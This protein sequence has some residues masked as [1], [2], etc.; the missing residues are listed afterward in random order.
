MI[1][2]DHLLLGYVTFSLSPSDIAP[3]M[4]RLLKRGI[5]TRISFEGKFN[6]SIFLVRSVESA[7]DGISFE[8]SCTKGGGGFFINHRYRYGAIIGVILSVILL[9]L[10][11]R[12]IWDVRVD[13]GADIYDESILA[14]LGELGLCAGACVTEEDL[15]KMEV[16][17]LLRFDEIGWINLYKKGAVVYAGIVM[18]ESTDE[19]QK[20]DGY[21][22]IVA[23]YDGVVEQ[24]IVKEGVALVE[25]GDTVFRGQTLISGVIPTELGGGFCYAKGSV[26]ARRAET[27]SVTVLQ[28]EEKKE[29]VSSSSGGYSIEIFGFTINILKKYGNRAEGCDII[30][31]K[32]T[33]C[34]GGKR[35]PISFA[36][37]TV[38]DYLT[39]PS[40]LSQGEMMS[41]ARSRLTQSIF[42]AAADGELL[43]ARTYGEFCADGYRMWADILISDDIAKIKEFD[44]IE[45]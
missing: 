12:L 22:N 2:V 29:I 44:F 32:H 40:N 43:S 8:R 19:A 31:K 15:A 14:S 5:S 41:L 7:L 24:M 18:R 10:S 28:N 6:V 30:E 42:D 23:E 33:L 9:F 34:I 20:K 16:E 45:E 27:V 37:Y 17:M 36:A 35:L 25:A 26:T 39:K 11:S 4:D 13:G 21:A 3:A 38:S 1:R